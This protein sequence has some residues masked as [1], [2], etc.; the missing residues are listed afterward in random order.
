MDVWGVGGNIQLTNQITTFG[1]NAD[2][3]PTEA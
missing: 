3:K 2:V 1:D